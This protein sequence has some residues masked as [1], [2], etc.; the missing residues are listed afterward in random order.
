MSEVSTEERLTV[1]VRTLRGDPKR[2]V[3]KLSLPMVVA[4]VV[5]A[6][7]N[8]V[9]GVWV[10]GLG[11]D[12]LAAL[13]LFFPFFMIVLSLAGGIAIGG[14]SALSRRIG[15]RDKPGA[16]SAASQS[17]AIGLGLALVLTAVSFP[18]LPHIFR[19]I[20][21]KGSALELTLKYGRVLIGGT[22][23]L[24]FS[25]I[26]GGIL[27]GEGDAGRAMRAMVLGS[28]L[29]VGLD[30][31]FIYGF[32]W[33]V[34]GAAWA[35]LLSIAVSGGLMAWWILI[36]PS[37]YVEAR[38]RRFRFDPGITAEILRVGLPAS[39]AQL[40]MALA[41]FGMNAIV[42]KAGGTDGV[43]VFVAAWRIVTF[44][45]VPLFG[46]AAGVTAVTAAA[47]GAR[48]PGRLRAGYS[49]GIR[50]G[51]L[52]E[53]A[54]LLCI[55]LFAPRLA[56][57]FTYS[58]QS[59]HLAPDVTRAMRTLAWFLPTVPLGMV[60]SS[61]FQGV[62]KGMNSMAV[63]ILRTLVFQVVFGYLFGLT[64]G[65]GIRGVWWGIVCGNVLAALISAGWGIDT[66]R[67][68]E[69]RFSQL[70]EAEGVAG[71]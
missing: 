66:I 31:V 30:P 33:G 63:T 53:A 71:S 39:F 28:L 35:T 18:L 55:L 38:L 10:A 56:Y 9:D 65:L 22:V 11:S 2:A 45:L 68:L 47:Y 50:L 5:Q 54:V 29:N 41:M 48:D 3:W 67:R 52:M 8:L 34:A 17:L 7:Y 21:A 37:T 49:Y 42:V 4:N 1:G 36:R 60:T 27:R 6:L 59:A 19:A 14:S 46:I 43:A 62:G 13:G 64:L 44:G 51:L 23:L 32:G 20:G 61:M 69:Q 26:A 12:A 16:D 25:N 40:S 57:L 15:A 24:V 70:A 58:K